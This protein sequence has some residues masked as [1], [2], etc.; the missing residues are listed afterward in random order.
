MLK[1]YLPYILLVAAAVLYWYVKNNQRSSAPVK[2]STEQTS[3]KIT[4]PAVLPGNEEQNTA[5]AR[6]DDPV[7]RAR[8][9]D[10]VGRARP[11][12]LVGRGFNRTAVHIIYSKHARCRMECRHIDESEVKE[13]LEKG[14]INYSRIEKDEK[15]KSFPVEGITHDKQRVRI[16][17]A[18][19][20]D[21]LVVVTVIDL[22]RDWSC[23]CK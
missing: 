10:L 4:V 8:P 6:P 21:A 14:E 23:D 2:P 11:D 19:K 17:F 13:I 7:G 5:D 1:K 9:D 16:V 20:K 3:T 12:G 15:G 18:P 22:D